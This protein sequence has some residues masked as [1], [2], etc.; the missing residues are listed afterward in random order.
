MD[1]TATT[2]FLDL[3]TGSGSVSTVAIEAGCEVKS[4]DDCSEGGIT[5]SELEC[6]PCLKDCV[7]N[8]TIPIIN[9]TQKITNQNKL[10]LVL[11][12]AVQQLQTEIDIL[13]AK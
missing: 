10:I 9:E 7:T 13:K 11:F 4:L 6:F 8:V 12:K 2:K 1:A 3:F 5:T